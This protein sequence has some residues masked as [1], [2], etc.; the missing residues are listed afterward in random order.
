MDTGTKIVL[1]ITVVFA[2]LG[3]WGLNRKKSRQEDENGD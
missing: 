1:A 3:I 2:L